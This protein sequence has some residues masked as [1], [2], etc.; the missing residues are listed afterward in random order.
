MLII[1]FSKSIMSK[2]VD[3]LARRE[4]KNVYRSVVMRSKFRR[5]F[6][7]FTRSWQDNIKFGHKKLSRIGFKWLSVRAQ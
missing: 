2:L 4:V 3:P 1:W 7:I 5:Y 6:G